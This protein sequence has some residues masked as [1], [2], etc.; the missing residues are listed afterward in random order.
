[1]TRGRRIEELLERAPS[2]PLKRRLYRVV[3]V[4]SYLR[5]ARPTFL[6]TSGRPN[7]CNPAEVD[8][9]YFS[10]TETTA[11]E[12]YLGGVAGTKAHHA[13]RL[14]FIAQADL[15]NVLARP[16]HQLSAAA[17]HLP[18][19]A[20]LRSVGVLD[21]PSGP[22]ARASVAAPCRHGHL[23]R[24]AT[25]PG[26]KVGLDLGKPEVLR[27]LELTG[28]DLIRPWRLAEQPTRLQE[29][30]SAVSRQQRVEALRLPS[31]H[32]VAGAELRFNVAIFPSSL[33]APSRL[34][35]LG[36]SGAILEDLP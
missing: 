34:R 31:V 22:P 10:E 25:K 26:E 4:L 7:R 23:R 12:E 30:G 18:A 9:L 33:V 20:A 16:S 27:A 24:L 1:M 35:V 8:C 5:S 13:P 19:S 17:P 32:R 6:Y 36:E 28:E 21:G 11:L 29:L 3:P 15:R 2:R 14:T